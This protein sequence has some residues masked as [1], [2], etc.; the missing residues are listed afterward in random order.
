MRGSGAPRAH[1]LAEG[2]W[3]PVVATPRSPPG[4]VCGLQNAHPHPLCCV[5]G[6]TAAKAPRVNGGAPGHTQLPWSTRAPPGRCSTAAQRTPRNGV[7]KCNSC[8][9]LA[10]RKRC[11]F[12]VRSRIR[13]R[14]RQEGAM[15]LYGGDRLAPPGAC[16]V[17]RMCC[18]MSQS[19]W[20]GG[21][22]RRLRMSCCELPRRGMESV[23][24]GFALGVAR[25]G[26]AGVGGWAVRRVK[27][28]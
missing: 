13:V 6:R 14:P 27:C 22:A 5:R 8:S 25:W 11:A 7:C 26:W 20:S 10:P 9:S 4:H 1:A 24:H 18:F 2:S 23:G 17:C 12:V 16:C 19:G 15:S 3:E 28:G 21:P